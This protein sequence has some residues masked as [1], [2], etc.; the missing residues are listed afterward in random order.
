MEVILGFEAPEYMELTVEVTGVL[1]R[2]AEQLIVGKEKVVLRGGIGLAV[3]AAGLLEE[4]FDRAAYEQ[5]VQDLIGHDDPSKL[6][7]A[8]ALAEAEGGCDGGFECLDFPMT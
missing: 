6:E 5:M 1:R 2:A 8:R 3:V 4:S 7:S